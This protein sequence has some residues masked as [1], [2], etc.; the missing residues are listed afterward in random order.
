MSLRI[1][2]ASRDEAP[3]LPQTA[4][5]WSERIVKLIPAEALGLYGTAV[6]LVHET[7]YRIHA[8]WVI[9]VICIALV[10]IIRSRS[11]SHPTTGKPQYV[12]V[13]IAVVSFLLWLVAL[14][15]ST[16][17]DANALPI[18]PFQL[19]VGLEFVGPLAALLWGTIVPYV[20]TGAK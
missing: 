11:T 15:T 12:A 8:L 2:P 10:V 14:G 5:D 6:S 4:D 7:P 16:G 1:I 13:G 19:P 9:V 17:T 20:Y 18:S 3:S